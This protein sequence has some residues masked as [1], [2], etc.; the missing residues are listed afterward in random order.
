MKL[1][2]SQCDSLAKEML[3]DWAVY[4]KMW[5][6][7]IDLTNYNSALNRLSIELENNAESTIKFYDYKINLEK[8]KWN[9]K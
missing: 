5:A 6:L 7:S 8:F 4:Q 3:T 1:T 9:I 2:R